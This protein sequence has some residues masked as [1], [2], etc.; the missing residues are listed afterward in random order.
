[1]DVSVYNMNHLINIVLSI[2]VQN[3]GI[4][5]GYAVKCDQVLCF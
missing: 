2:I 3:Q 1:M 4:T 5:V